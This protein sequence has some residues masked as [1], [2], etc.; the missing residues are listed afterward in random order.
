MKE[1]YAL[2]WLPFGPSHPVPMPVKGR[3]FLY[4]LDIERNFPI[5]VSGED[6]DEFK[7]RNSVVCSTLNMVAGALLGFGYK[8]W[9]PMDDPRK[10][11]S[12]YLECYSA[13]LG[14]GTLERLVISVASALRSKN[15]STVSKNVIINSF[16]LKINRET[17][18]ND[19]LLDIWE[20]IIDTDE[21]DLACFFEEFHEYS[22]RVVVDK[23]HPQNV[24]WFLYARA[25]SM[26]YME[27]CGTAKKHEAISAIN[28]MDNETARGKLI[29]CL[30]SGQFDR[31]LL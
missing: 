22:E 27:I 13:K 7:K 11:L 14:S 8:E 20:C 10:I 1:E 6:L 29:E 28:L 17:L 16:Q 9:L 12:D 5:Y 26:V 19:L 18:Y 2:I 24:R 4:D 3:D 25:V 21:G 15:G 30:R 31:N 23:L